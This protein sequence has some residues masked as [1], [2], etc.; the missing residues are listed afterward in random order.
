MRFL[1]GNYPDLP[2]SVVHA[3]TRV[4]LVRGEFVESLYESVVYSVSRANGNWTGELPAAHPRVGTR[5]PRQ[6]LL[7]LCPVDRD[8]RSGGH[9]ARNRLYCCRIVYVQNEA[10]TRGI[11]ARTRTGEVRIVQNRFCLLNTKEKHNR[12]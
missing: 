3:R 2:T 12:R 4:G 8:R 5:V 9:R 6:S 11:H 7:S 1:T 10:M